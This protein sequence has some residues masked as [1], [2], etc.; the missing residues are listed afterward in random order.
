MK[1]VRGLLAA[2]ALLLTACS[3]HPAA[4]TAREDAAK[5]AEK[6]FAIT[7]E[8]LGVALETR[9]LRVKHSEIKG[10][11]PAMTMEFTVSAGDA[12]NARVGQLI[13]AELVEGADEEFRLEKIWPADPAT[14]AA[15]EAAAKTLTQETVAL[16]RQAFREVGEQVPRFALFD[17]EGRVVE[18]TR[19]R[20]RQVMINFIFTR[21]T[22]AKMC[23]AAVARFQQT[24]RL[25][26][27][28]GV[29]N[30]ELVSFTLDPEYDTPGILKE[31]VLQRAID[32]GNYS[33][34]TGP[35][36]AIKSLLSQFGIL[37]DFK[38]DLLDHTATTVLLD[39]TGR[40]VHRADG[41]DWDVKEFVGKMKKV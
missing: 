39:E 41:S 5:A 21:C 16:G 30:L 13:R 40:I 2:F 12:A 34:L 14:V 24:Q 32:T 1:T 38:G 8:I 35:Q 7:G 25:A 18:S 29:A 11:M 31:Y 4:G 27:E 17:Q 15:V 36:M 26:R 20:G 33:F 3:K 6:R 19:F 23:P 10:Y 37:A 28:A 9:T 22:V